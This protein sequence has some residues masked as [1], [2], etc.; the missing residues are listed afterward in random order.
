MNRALDWLI[1]EMK[2][3]CC[4]LE[5]YINLSLLDIKHLL[6]LSSKGQGYGR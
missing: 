3:N 5:K 2:Q 4:S 6:K 1:E